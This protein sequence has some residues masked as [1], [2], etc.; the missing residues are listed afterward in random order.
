VE[1]RALGTVEAHVDGQP[2]DIGHPRQQR[3]LAALLADAN[4]AVSADQLVY[5]VWGDHFPARARHALYSYL[6]RLRQ[7]LGGASGVAVTRRSAGYV[8]SADPE[9]I[10]L[11]RFRRLTDDARAASHDGDALE[12][13]EQA[14]RLWRGEAF[15]GLDTPWLTT[16]RDRLHDEWFTAQLFRNDLA[17]RRGMHAELLPELLELAEAHP[18]DEQLAAQLMLALYRGGRP[19]EA[20]DL[21]QRLRTRLVDDLGTDPGPPLRRLHQRILAADPELLAPAD[22]EL[23]PPADPGYP[24]K[25]TPRQLP[26]PPRQFAG[27]ADELAELTATLDTRTSAALVGAG[28]VGKSWL[29]LRWAHDNLERFPDGQLYVNLRGFDPNGR[30]MPPEDAVRG[31]LDAFEV[32]AENVPVGFEAQAAMYRSLLA[33]R[34]MLVV[35]D[36]AHDTEQVRP[37]LPGSPTCLVVITSRDRLDGLVARDDAWPLEL[38]TL[39]EREA[40]DLLAM[41]IGRRVDTEPGPVAEL[42]GHCARLPLALAIVAARAIV[43]PDFPLRALAEELRDEHDRLDA[44]RTGEQALDVRAVFAGSYHA[45]AP[46]AAR[47]FRLLGLSPGPDISPHAAASL[48][49]I[50]VPHARRLLAGLTR[51][52]LLDEHVPGRYRFHDL[53]RTYAAERAAVEDSE[54]QRREAVHRL[55]DCYLHTGFAA[56]RHLAPHWVPITPRPPRPGVSW[57]QVNDY[58]EA[59]E[60]FT[61]ELSTALALI[62]EAG[63]VGFDVHAWQLPW[64]LSTFLNRQGYWRHRTTTQ[65]TALAAAIRLGDGDAEA[66]TRQ[67][68]GRGCAMLGK[69]EDALTHL[70][71]ALALYREL[72]DRTGQATVHFSFSQAWGLRNDY[73]EALTHSQQALDLYRATGDRVWE[74]FARSGVGRCHAELGHHEQALTHCREALEL[75]REL[76]N[77]DGE[78]HTL[79]GLGYANHNLG[80]RTEAVTCL[81][82]AARLFHQLGDQYNEATTLTRLG[83]THQAGGDQPAAGDAWRYALGILDDLG[84][85]DASAVRARLVGLG[86]PS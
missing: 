49:A 16:L 8:L 70:R 11:H 14:L 40:T 53:L 80:N 17:L 24:D 23:L 55:L 56:E 48:A 6:S 41:R 78:A 15:A 19:T 3:V 75:V 2:V 66:T 1:F 71:R 10:D 84:H 38:S 27:R 58:A 12:L 9:T 39:S 31:F 18:L 74:G 42:L 7:A 79:Y 81:Q 45:L 32:R 28:G 67:L 43:N 73:A 64:T 86:E 5:R 29:A 13:V 83:E 77:T 33:E 65:Q 68:L 20:M 47:L 26:T 51:A 76:G 60:W 85:P 82:R 37:L 50:D 35:L 62:D 30:P 63:R 34:R 69:H 61:A 59:M 72:G 44:L 4:R 52:H 36:N 25:P 54:H 57:V 46:D 21:Y 22:A